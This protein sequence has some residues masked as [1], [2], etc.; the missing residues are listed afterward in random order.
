MPNNQPLTVFALDC[1]AT[2]WRLYRAEYEAA[3]A[4]ARLISEPQPSPMTSF[5]DRRLPAAI[6]LDPK[7]EALESFGE[8][9]QQQLE[10]EACRERVR[11]YFKPCIGSHLVENPLPHQ[12]RFTHARALAYTRMLLQAV[13]GQVRQEKWRSG[14]FDDRVCFTF[15]YPI[16]WKYDHDGVV[17]DEFARTVRECFDPA[18]DR[19]RF[20]AEPEGAILSLSH[21]G[22]LDP[23]KTG[24]VTCI[25]DIGGSTTD[26][27]AGRIDPRSGTLEYLG[28]YG[29]PFGGGLYDAELAKRIADDLAIPASALAD[30]PSAILSLRVSAQ[31]LK[32]SL[33]RQLAHS[34][35]ARHVP[36]RTVTLVMRDGSIYRRVVALDEA[37]FREVTGA[38]DSQFRNLIEHALA[39]MPIRPQDI[40]PVVL[41]G[42]GSQLF[43]I[44]GY[45]RERFGPQNIILADNPEEIVVQGIGLEYGAASRAAGP[46]TIIP[47]EP[48]AEKREPEIPSPEA[49]DAWSLKS[50]D[51][52]SSPLVAGVTKIGRGE[53]NDLQIDTLKVSRFHA[54][55]KLSAGVLEVVDLGST[56][57]TFVN[58]ERLTPR[59]P[60]TLNPG[61]E[62][63]FGAAKFIC[64][65]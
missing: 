7:G 43:S 37:R 2:N 38:L 33:S 56:N 36:Q 18:F 54:E 61:D 60:R 29:E 44:L 1:G 9:A 64:S 16:H 30:D 6:C 5:V 19:I 47:P 32:E 35:Q 14:P 39:A 3:G 4:C 40:G 13:L 49:G 59:E 26:I 62:V 8:V 53:G 42:G 48:P 63:C 15:A 17:F 41:V 65:K 34:E 28:H 22:Q 50:A 46:V 58:G 21:R 27:V 24:K 45:L 10:D 31:R 55:V 11:E 12:K 51:G 25:V 20:V 52:S 23:Q 57:G